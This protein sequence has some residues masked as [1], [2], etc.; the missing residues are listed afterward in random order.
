MCSQGSI[1]ERDMQGI[2]ILH[3]NNSNNSSS[4][5]IKQIHIHQLNRLVKGINKSM[6]RKNIRV[7]RC[8]NNNYNYNKNNC[9]NLLNQRI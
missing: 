8:S 6:R 2:I 9:N 1:E 7:I 5:S 3:N 4:N